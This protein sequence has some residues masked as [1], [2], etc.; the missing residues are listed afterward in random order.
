MEMALGGRRRRVG[1]CT[2]FEWAGDGEKG[3]GC[4]ASQI[5]GHNE[6]RD[7]LYAYV[8]YHL[9]HP[10]SKAIKPAQKS[11]VRPCG[12]LKEVQSGIGHL[13]SISSCDR[14]GGTIT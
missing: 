8:S 10:G 13:G 12:E 4:A 9:H 1:M 7:V 11:D 6:H 2:T 3:V 14:V 5:Y